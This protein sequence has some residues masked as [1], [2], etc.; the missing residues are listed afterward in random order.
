[1]DPDTPRTAR[2]SKSSLLYNLVHYPKL[3]QMIFVLGIG[4]TLQYGIQISVLSSPSPFIKAFL[5]ETWLTR[6]GSPMPE[7][8]ITLLWSLIVSVF[9]IGGFFGALV[10]GPLIG[11]HG[12]RT[13]QV[14]NS[15]L[16]VLA[17]ILFA[18]S[19]FVGSF[20]MILVVRFIFGFNSGLGM[21]IHMQ[22]LSEVAPRKL[23]GFTTASCS[24]FVT[25]GKLCGQILGLRDVFG[26]DLMWPYAMAFCAVTSLVQCVTLPFLPESPPYLLMEKQDEAGCMQAIQQLW[27]KGDHSTEIEEMKKEKTAMK[28]TKIMGI[29]DVLRDQSL[30][31]QLYVMAVVMVALQLTGINAIYFYSYDVFSK[32]GFSEDLIPY[33]GLGLGVC[34]SSATILSSFL[35]ERFGRKSLILAGYALLIL[36]LVLLTISLSLQ[37]WFPWLSYS[38]AAFITLFTFLFGLGP[39]AVSLVICVELFNQSSRAAAMVLA[40][41][42]NWMGLYLTGMVF[43]YVVSSLGQFCFLF[44][45]AV[46]IFT[47]ICL[48]IFLPETKGKSVLEVTEEFYR[49]K[50][51]W[52]LVLSTEE[53]SQRKEQV[54]CTRL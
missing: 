18:C 8:T 53:S 33:I 46:S 4:G 30:R 37:A 25:F 16:P 47:V 45:L 19:K 52:K 36:D 20:E 54:L 44:F 31:L 34:E 38:S 9:S 49:S 51:P 32:A 15:L 48:Y 17:S 41:S 13:C 24:F 3:F 40:G 29:L 26:T 1:M 12:K 2:P 6:S 50:S 21:N 11:R 27:G 10:S 23:R 42:L 14:W 43:P 35:I 7:G 5:N 22:Y 28:N 39:S